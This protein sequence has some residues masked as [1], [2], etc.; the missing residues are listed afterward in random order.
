MEILAGVMD[1][2][3]FRAAAHPFVFKLLAAVLVASVV[4]WLGYLMGL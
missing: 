3:A 1:V 4:G 2:V